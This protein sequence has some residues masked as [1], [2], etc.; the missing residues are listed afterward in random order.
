MH[1]FFSFDALAQDESPQAL[2]RWQLIE[3]ISNGSDVGTFE[4]M[5]IV[6]KDYL[7]A[8]HISYSFPND[9]NRP[10]RNVGPDGYLHST[11]K[12]KKSWHFFNPAMKYLP[13]IKRDGNP[14]MLFLCVKTTPLETNVKDLY[15]LIM[16]SA[17]K[18]K[19]RAFSANASAVREAEGQVGFLKWCIQQNRE[20]LQPKSA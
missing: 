2:R 8:G 19:G 11:W 18:D 15:P 7:G 1:S 3:R 20:W 13:D 16:V 6:F 17:A 10:L 9:G 4:P 14:I 5:T 12:G